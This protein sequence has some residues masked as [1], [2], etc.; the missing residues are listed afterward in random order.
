M[1]TILIIILALFTLTSCKFSYDKAKVEESY[2]SF[3][4]G[5]DSGGGGGGGC[6]TQDPDINYSSLTVDFSSVAANGT[7]NLIDDEDKVTLT[8]TLLD[9]NQ[10]PIPGI[11]PTFSATDSYSLN[12]P[13]NSNC[14]VSDLDGK[15]FCT[16]SSGY[17]EPKTITTTTPASISALS[18]TV[19][20]TAPPLTLNMAACLEGAYDATAA[21]PQIMSTSGMF[22]VYIPYFSP[23][24]VGSSWFT[25]GEAL[26]FYQPQN[27]LID[28]VLVQLY[29]DDAAPVALDAKSA[30][31][32]NN[33]S[34]SDPGQ[35]AGSGLTF[36]NVSNDYNASYKINI[37]H[38][39][40]LSIG[41]LDPISRTSPPIDFTSTLTNYRPFQNPLAIPLT[42]P[43]SLDP[44]I[45]KGPLKCLRSGDFDNN[46]EI[47]NSD[48]TAMQNYISNLIGINPF[49]TDVNLSGYHNTDMTFNG[50]SK[51]H[52][53]PSSYVEDVSIIDSQ[54]VDPTSIP[55]SS[56]WNDGQ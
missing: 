56:P 34:I 14:S 37:I 10:Q 11:T 19:D 39:N 52:L 41:L 16:L 7:D 18:T 20:F 38:R 35:P 31:L 30:Y 47:D 1:K 27:T 54:L 44:Y 13:E 28:W 36:T 6:P 33:G 50:S 51:L 9:C 42:P 24:V 22:N 2:G 40:H 55:R 23:Y 49:T 46:L 21:A 17:A 26:A 15:S 29:T 4:G 48:I 32:H 3:E 25:N 45:M 12:I 53:L 5:G 8:Y 43:N